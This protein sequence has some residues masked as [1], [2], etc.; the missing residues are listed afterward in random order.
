MKCSS[1][2][3]VKKA[4][5]FSDLGIVEA[6]HKLGLEEGH[7]GGVVV[8]LANVEVVEAVVA[9]PGEV[10]FLAWDGGENG[11][12]GFRRASHVVGDIP[13]DNGDSNVSE[14][15][16]NRILVVV[17]GPVH[18][19][20]VETLAVLLLPNVLVLLDGDGGPAL[21]SG[22]LNHVA[23]VTW[24]IGAVSIDL[25]APVFSI[26]RVVA[27]G[28]HVVV[29]GVAVGDTAWGAV[30]AGPVLLA[31]GLALVRVPVTEVVAGAIVS[32]AIAL[33]A[34]PVAI[35][36][37]AMTPAVRVVPVIVVAPVIV[38]VVIPTSK[39]SSLLLFGGELSALDGLVEFAIDF[40]QHAAGGSVARA[41]ESAEGAGGELDGLADP[42][43]R[44]GWVVGQ[45]GEELSGAEALRDGLDLFT[46]SF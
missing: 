7:E 41:G 11:G 19:V 43:V 36:V 15:G 33:D 1:L 46:V 5:A 21:G 3:S 18:R 44:G 38:V 8:L 39:L 45:G 20:G 14:G 22:A 28:S 16:G 34:V 23:V 13:V 42:F 32:V 17:S 31:E 4:G 25:S 10:V 26:E 30:L 12:V 27:E 24:V 37:T 40:T 29:E 9:V 6:C 2:P 35:V